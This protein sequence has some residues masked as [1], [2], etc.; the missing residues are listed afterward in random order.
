MDIYIYIYIGLY[1]N[2]YTKML[3]ELLLLDCNGYTAKATIIQYI[4]EI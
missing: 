2:N 1:I 4:S 3:I